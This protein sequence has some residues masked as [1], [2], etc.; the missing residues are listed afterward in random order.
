[1]HRLDVTDLTPE[2]AARQIAH[3]LAARPGAA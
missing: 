3:I 1:V 2:A